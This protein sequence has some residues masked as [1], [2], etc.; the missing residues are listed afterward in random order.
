M[1][2][3]ANAFVVDAGASDQRLAL[4]AEILASGDGVVIFGG[5]LALRSTDH[6][7]LCE[8]VDPAPS[9]HRCMH[10]YEVLVENARRALAGS[11]LIDLLPHLPQRWLVVEDDG[12]G[13]R[14][15]WPAR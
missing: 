5:M 9:A 13:G 2:G 1:N 6:E 8:V 10:E 4:A 12:T 11:R 15:V 14:Q 7:L 3:H